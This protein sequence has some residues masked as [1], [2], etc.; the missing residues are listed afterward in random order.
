MKVES[1]PRLFGARLCF[2]CLWL[3]ASLV[4]HGHLAAQGARPN[5]VLIFS[6]DQGFHDV[7]CYGSEIPTPAIDSIARQGI[8]FSSWYAASSI[9]TPSR[10]GLLTGRNPS[11]SQ[12]RLLGALMYLSDTDRQRGIRPGETTIAEVLRQNGYATGLIGKWH[13]GHGSRD[14]LPTQHGFDMFRG[15]TAGCIDYFTMTYGVQPDWYHNNRLVSENGYA[16]DLITDEAVD[17]LQRTADTAS[18]KPFFLFLAYNAP[19]FGKGWSPAENR[20]VNIMQPRGHELKRVAQIPDK[21]RRE[22]AA[23][24]L[25]LDDGIQRVLKQLD[26]LELS[27]DTLVIFMTDHGGDPVYGGSNAPLRGNKATLF[28]GGIRVPCVMRWPGKIP[29]GSNSDAVTSALDIFPTLCAVADIQPPANDGLDLSSHLLEAGNV[30]ARQLFWEIGAHAELQRQP[31][32]AVRD[33]RWKYLQDNQKQEYL[34]DLQND[35]RETTNLKDREPK[36]F[37]RLRS[38]RD[39]LRTEMGR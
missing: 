37:A 11:R 1:T 30:P 20:T 38:L 35:R 7:G 6:D 2:W 33:G 21:I 22:F 19:H 13:L 12:D 17:F 25:A 24:T 14:F 27:Q 16:T 5:V 18:Q 32:S 8:K 26:A 28:E 29:A 23:M 10:F 34:F 31:W 9:C 15:H 39:Q 4:V 3:V 36:T